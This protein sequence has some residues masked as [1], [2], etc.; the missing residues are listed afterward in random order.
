V[1]PDR[2][3]AAWNAAAQSGTGANAWAI[4]YSEFVLQ[5]WRADVVRTVSAGGAMAAQIRYTA[6]GEPA[7]F[8]IYDIAGGGSGLSAPDG[9]PD[10]EDYQAFRNV[11]GAEDA[12]VDFVGGD[13]NPPGDGSV[14]GNDFA[15]GWVF[16]RPTNSSRASLSAL[17]PVRASAESFIHVALGS[18]A[19]RNSN[20]QIE[21]F[22]LPSE[23]ATLGGRPASPIVWLIDGLSGGA[24]SRALTR[25]YKLIK[26][27]A[28]FPA[29]YE[30]GDAS[31][32]WPGPTLSVIKLSAIFTGSQNAGSDIIVGSRSS[33]ANGLLTD[34]TLPIFLTSDLGANHS[35]ILQPATALETLLQLKD[36]DAAFGG[37]K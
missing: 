13:G 1:T 6:Y 23:G 12:L 10:G 22:L 26:N 18:D 21:V 25:V 32:G 9:N 3:N 30:R 24:L 4:E 35:S 29:T 27:N 11:F 31:S 7:S 33:L 28:V 5:N 15:S 2:D 19:D 20:G 8:S 36:A 14:D 17:S 37:I 34:R 16:L